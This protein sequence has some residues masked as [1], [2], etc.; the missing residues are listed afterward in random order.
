MRASIKLGRVFGVEL[1]LHYSWFVIALLIVFSLAAHFRAV[2]AAWGEGVIWAA[3]IVTG[4]LF[5][6]GLFAHELSHA[7]VAKARGLP[8]HRITL[9]LLGGMAQIEKEAADAKTEFWMGIAGP[10]ASAL[11]GVVMLGLA[12]AFGWTWRAEPATP[13]VAIL[14][15]LGYINLALGAFNMIPGFPLDGG[16]V[17]RAIIWWITRNADRATRVATTVGQVVA[18]LFIMYGLLHFFR[19]EGLGGLWMAF[20]GWFLLQAASASRLHLQAESLL[21]GLRVRDVMSTD[22][23][24]VDGH[25]VLQQFVDDELLRTGRRCFLVMENSRVAGLITPNDVGKVE[26]ERWP[27]M[28]VRDAMRPLDQIHSV[29]PD[30]TAMEAVEKMAGEDVNQLPVMSDGQLQ[31]IVTRGHIL[32]VLQSRAALAGR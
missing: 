28:R 5:F 4:V 14:V 32:Q 8:I 3:A 19:G 29:A 10:I 16:R 20:I 15:W 25:T 23:S 22:C 27:L 18:V 17:L 2:N 24:R 13:G 31:G 9:F 7:L 26:R 21:R 1:G 30:T 12:A 11:I 6:A